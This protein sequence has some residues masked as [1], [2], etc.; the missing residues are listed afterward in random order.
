M[1]AM[2][3]APGT[4]HVVTFHVERPH[5]AA[6]VGYV[7]N[8]LMGSEEVIIPRVHIHTLCEYIHGVK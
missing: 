4:G 2:G 1:V 3:C 6:R 7:H 5:T 8:L